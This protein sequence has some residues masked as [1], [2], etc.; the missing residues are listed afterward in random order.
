MEKSALH[1]ARRLAIGLFALILCWFAFY[2]FKNCKYF[3]IMNFRSI[4][5]LALGLVGVGGFAYYQYHRARLP[6][7]AIA[8]YGPHASLNDSI[9]GIKQGLADAGL[10]A[11]DDIRIEVQDVGFDT[12]LIPQM[13]TLFKSHSPRVLVALTTPVAQFA[14]NTFLDI[15]IVFTAI[16]D[17]VEAGL[18]HA[19]KQAL[20]NVT[21][22]SDQQNL[23]AMLAFSKSLLPKAERVGLLYST[24]EINDHA[25]HK[26]MLEACEAHAMELVAIPINHTRDLALAVQQLKGKVDFLYVGVSGPIQPALPTIAQEAQAIDLPIINANEGAVYEGLVLASFGVNYIKVGHAAGKLA[27][28]CLAGKSMAELPVYY[29]ALEDHKAFVSRA[30]AER[31]GVSIPSGLRNTTILEDIPSQ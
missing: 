29:P 3:H 12:A 2:Y 19:D 6:L 23:G 17:P 9:E 27:A 21:G 30:Q 22:S 20:G 31:L 15:P 28:G 24:S 13:L 11:G 25:L 10:V 4:I 7:V 16:T 8:N 5:L 1:L 18:V 26:M 14:K